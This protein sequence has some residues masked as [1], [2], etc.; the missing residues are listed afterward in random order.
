MYSIGEFSK[1]TQLPIKTLRYYHE[2]QLLVP[3]SVDSGSGYR[4]Y[5]ASNVERARV[6]RTLKELEF[7]L[8]EIGEILVGCDDD[9]QLLD[10][11]V[12]R[13]VSADKMIARQREIAL[14]LGSII[15][16][17]KQAR[18]LMQHMES[19]IVEKRVEPVLIGGIRMKGRYSD[20]SQGFSKLG[21]SLGRF[22]TG[23]A[24]CLFFDEGYRETDADFEPCVP[25][26]RVVER[27][28]ISV[29]ELPG[30]LA[31]SL[32][33]TG[34]YDEVGPAYEALIAYAK[35]KG[36]VLVTPCR[37]IYIK[38]PGM[39]FKGNPQKYVTE[40]QVLIESETGKRI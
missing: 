24:F 5:G 31:I 23:K 3:T 29:R 14:M 1:I 10:H 26:R 12:E 19:G 22:I 18:S 8:K 20:C 21:K 17:V 11:L 25:I 15:S 39:I 4:Y 32:I 30:G 38:G 13:Q 34:P 16:N 9:S 7:S 33:H 36:Y 27:D 2:R 35:T 37:E 28:G 6:I 40:V